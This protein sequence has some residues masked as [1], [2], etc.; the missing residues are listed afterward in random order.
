M[1]VVGDFEYSKRDLVGH[2]AFAVV[3][4]GRHRQVSPAG[5]GEVRIGG[6]NPPAPAAAAGL[7]LK[8]GEAAGAKAPCLSSPP[9]ACYCARCHCRG[10]CFGRARFVLRPEPLGS[11]PPT[12]GSPGFWFPRPVRAPGNECSE[13]APV[14]L[15]RKACHLNI[16]QLWRNARFP[17]QPVA[18]GWMALWFSTP[19]PALSCQGPAPLRSIIADPAENGLF[20]R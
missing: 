6:P 12:D 4:R 13:N 1:E 2:G 16:P 3:F 19:I 10:V 15:L 20:S 18:W 5:R 11:A 8:L 7:V 14:G 9:W 17:A